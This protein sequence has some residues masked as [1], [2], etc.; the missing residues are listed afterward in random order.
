MATI[1]L[2]SLVGKLNATSHNALDAAAGLCLAR[3]NYN[4]EL[5]HLLLKLIEPTGTDVAAILRHFEIDVSQLSRDLTTSMDRFKTGNSRAPALSPQVVALIREAWLMASI[6]YQA[7]QT[8]SGHLLCALVS[9]DSLARIAGGASD[10]LDKISAE[11]LRKNLATIVAESTEQREAEGKP[12][13]GR[14]QVQRTGKAG[15]LDQF[16]IDITAR[17]RAGGVDPVLCREKEIRQIV[18][19]LT[20]RRQ[21]NPILTGEAGVGKTAVVEGF[22]LR[23]VAGDVPPAL[24]NVELRSL[25]L[26]LLQAGAGIKGEFESRLKSVIEEVKSSPTPIVLFIDEAHT[27]IGAG[28]AAGQGDAANLLKPALARGELRTIAATTWA[29]YKKYFERDAALARRF[30]VIRVDEPEEAAAIKMIRGLAETLE[31][32][33]RVRILDEAIVESVRLSHRYLTGRQL[34]DKSISLL[35]TAAARVAISHAATPPAIDD[36]QRRIQHLE[37]EINILQ[38]ESVTGADH[39]ARLEQLRQE[40][41]NAK[42]KLEELDTR[43]KQEAE[44][45]EKL[46]T[47]REQLEADAQRQAADAAGAGSGKEGGQTAEKRPPESADAPPARAPPDGRTTR[48]AARGVGCARRAAATRSRATNR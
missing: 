33:H 28:G 10:L 44:L 23:I 16:T 14:P 2:K 3:T 41:A 47:I 5:E 18:D 1:D 15:A 22:A 21:N 19:I 35:D 24:R 45:I 27:L 34:P 30:Q 4:V 12:E 20:R 17:A 6:N 38:R 40:Q 25:D 36:V 46:R 26:G 42:A 43:W 48:Q 8:R 29:E 11:S 9:D 37:V 13:A 7:S 32:H 31:K 39:V